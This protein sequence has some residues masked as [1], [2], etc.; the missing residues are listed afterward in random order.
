MSSHAAELAHRLARSAEAVCRH[1]LSN[2]HREGR[3]WI[4]GDV[5]NTPGR[6][7]YVRL[8][9]LLY[10]KGAAGKWTEYVAPRVMLRIFDWALSH[11][12][13]TASTQHNASVPREV[14]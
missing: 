4:V 5:A 1:Y 13:L 10:G 8:Y 14:A 3:Y 9:G 6:S 7:L 12:R 2:G 11:G